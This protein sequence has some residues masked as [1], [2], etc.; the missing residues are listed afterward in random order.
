MSTSPIPRS[1]TRPRRLGRGLATLT[2][3]AA[4]TLAVSACGTTTDSSTK[5]QHDNPATSG[6]S[7]M[8]G[9]HGSA[10]PGMGGSTMATGDG[11]AATAAGYRFVPGGIMQPP[12]QPESF[13]FRLLGP[14]GLP[15]TA[16]DPEQTKLM[17]FYLIRADLTGFQHVH[18]TL[19]SD[20]TWTAPTTPVS[21]GTYRTYVQFVAHSNAAA[22]T[23]TLSAPFTAGGL[24]TAP[25][26]LPAPSASTTV[27]GYTLALRG[28]LTAAAPSPLTITITKDGQPVTD[29]QSY[30]DTYAHVT[31]IHQGDLAFAHIHTENTATNGPGGP[32]LALHAQLPEPGNWRMFI[33]FHTAGVLHTAALTV[34]TR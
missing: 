24:A 5:P 27:D 22:G 1:H 13:Q 28:G 21:A 6:H 3:G 32:D 9:M 2:V 23:L 20:D 15:V 7:G 10:M 8:L 31:A 25:A 18:P 33:Q 26:P 11:L 29:L 34:A 12:G 19:A 14:E 4:L 30:L 17:H 16:F